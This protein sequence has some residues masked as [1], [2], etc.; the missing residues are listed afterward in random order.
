MIAPTRS[1][2]LADPGLWAGAAG[3]QRR[4]RPTLRAEAEHHPRPAPPQRPRRLA[5]HL[6]GLLTDGAAVAL[7]A[8]AEAAARAFSAGSGFLPGQIIDRAI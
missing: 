7:P 1:A 4:W 5:S 8:R 2:S 6:D 3:T